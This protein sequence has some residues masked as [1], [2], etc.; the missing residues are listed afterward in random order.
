MRLNNKGMTLV[1]LVLAMLILGI[2]G[3]SLISCFVSSF[4]MLNRATLYKNISTSA[5]ATVELGEKQDP[6]SDDYEVGVSEKNGQLTVR[7]KKDNADK[8]LTM[9][10]QFI[11]GNANKEDVSAN[12]TYKEFLPSNFSYDVPAE[13]VS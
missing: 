5:A 8:Q 2:I 3:V 4:N 11:L 9:N 6:I 1:E 7:Y 12:L 13:V 10:G